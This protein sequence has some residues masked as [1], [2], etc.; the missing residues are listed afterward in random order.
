MLG[1]GKWSLRKGGISL[2]RNAA[3]ERLE[4]GSGEHSRRVFLVGMRTFVG[5]I[6]SD[7][8]PPHCSL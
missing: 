6:E 1:E 3:Q 2:N 7:G 4:F 8:T 5:P